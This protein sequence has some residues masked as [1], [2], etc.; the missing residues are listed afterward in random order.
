[1]GNRLF[2]N[3]RFIFF[4]SKFVN[5]IVINGQKEKARKL[6]LKS[7]LVIRKS[8]KKDPFFL[9]YLVFQNLDSC[10]GVR[11]FKKGNQRFIIPYVL[12]PTQR[13]QR[14]I[15]WFLTSYTN[16]KKSSSFY[17]NFSNEFQK[18]S[19]GDPSSSSLKKKILFYKKSEAGKSNFYL[20][21]NS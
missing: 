20:N 15:S 11:S 7:C 19:I 5:K 1:M 21:V 6:L 9:I 4:Y 13:A 3:K 2:I 17:N 10:V 18:L 12:S 16:N 14:S 8:F